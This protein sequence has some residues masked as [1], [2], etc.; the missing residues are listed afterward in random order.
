MQRLGYQQL[1]STTQYFNSSS[2]RQLEPGYFS[3]TAYRTEF[4]GYE[5]FVCLRIDPVR[6]FYRERT[7]L[8]HIDEIYRLHAA[9]CR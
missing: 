5:Q 6:R 3:Y 4:V 1:E 9:E 7:V 2:I 8:D